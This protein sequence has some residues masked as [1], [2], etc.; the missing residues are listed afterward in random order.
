LGHWAYDSVFYHIY[1]LGFC[2]A[3]PENDFCSPAD[4]RLELIYEWLEHIQNLGVNALYLG[5]LFESSTHGYDTVDYYHVDRRLGNNERLSH[6]SAVLHQKGI[7]LILD[8][9]FNHVGRDFWAFRDVLA[10]G[11]QS[12]YGDWFQGLNFHKHSPYNDPFTYEN[13]NGHHNLVKLNLHNPTVKDHLFQ[14]V[15]LWIREFAIDGLRLDV[16]DSLDLTF[17]KELSVFCKSRRSDFWLMG[18]VIHGDY[19][20]W[21]NPETLDSV[22]NYVGYK[23]LYSSHIDRNYFELA[24]TLNR[25]FGDNGMYRDLLLYSFADNHDVNRVA[26]Q[27]KNPAHLYPL[28]S[29]LFTMPGIP[30]IYYG[31]EWGI[32][33]K[34]TSRSDQAL[35]PHL[36]FFQ[37][38][39]NSPHPDLPRVIGRLAHVRHHSPALRY[40]NYHPLLVKSEQLAFA[41]QTQ[42]EYLIVA[43]N[44]ADKPVPL[45]L[46]IPETGKKQLID[47]LNE[48]DHFPVQGGKAHIPVVNPCWARIMKVMD[49]K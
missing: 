39:H 14:A 15:D 7:R 42:D 20:K 34:R 23:G 31:S 25:Q 48:G 47:L 29:L 6:L 46:P 11:A 35:R 22:T 45:E 16:S 5:P 21:V 19:R 13:W 17:L 33:G 43:V 1:P 3:P 28:Y 40:G 32:E 49:Q 9:V 18:E 8:G 41:R 44:A 10:H 37:I 26:S 38:S 12:A 27:L 30:S 36:D 4:H 2:G 24:H